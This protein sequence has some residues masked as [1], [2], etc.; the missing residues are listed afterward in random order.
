MLSMNLMIDNAE[1]NG[2][3]GIFY[4]TLSLSDDSDSVA[5]SDYYVEMQRLMVVIDFLGC[6]KHDHKSVL[7]TVI[8]WALLVCPT[9]ETGK[10]PQKAHGFDAILPDGT[11]PKGESG[12]W[13]GYN[14]L[15]LIMAE[16][17]LRLLPSDK[18]GDDFSTWDE[19]LTNP[20]SEQLLALA[21][22]DGDPELT[23]LISSYYVCPDVTHNGQYHDFG[24]LA[25]RLEVTEFPD[26]KSYKDSE[27]CLN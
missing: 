23:E 12:D 8:D 24:P 25:H 5:N 3:D 20:F 10:C 11:H 1:K 26:F 15:A 16:T 2:V 21:P 7:F 14:A 13:L 27:K 4:H 17:S 18:G 22:P 19:A 9:V 6:E